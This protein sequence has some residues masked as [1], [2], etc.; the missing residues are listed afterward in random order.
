MRP[1]LFRLSVLLPILLGCAARGAAIGDFKTFTSKAGRFTAEFPGDPPPSDQV[2]NTKAGNA[3]T[4]YFIVPVG[5]TAGYAIAYTDVPGS[6]SE[7]QIKKFNIGKMLDSARDGIARGKQ[8]RIVNE[9]TVMLDNWPGRDL[10]LVGTGS[11]DFRWR[12]YQVKTRLYQMT[13]GWQKGHEPPKE[14]VDKFL[15]SLKISAE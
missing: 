12:C 15:N 14:I 6:P 9:S 11:E 2:T 13:V 7:A 1:V 3:T 4:H 10:E 5:A 8:A